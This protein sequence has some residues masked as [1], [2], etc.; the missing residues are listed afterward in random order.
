[1]VETQLG[2]AGTLNSTMRDGSKKIKKAKRNAKDEKHR[3]KV[4]LTYVW[5]AFQL[6][7]PLL[8]TETI[9]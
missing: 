1:M 6:D 5:F 7:R 2:D 3:Y 8:I 9:N 4:L